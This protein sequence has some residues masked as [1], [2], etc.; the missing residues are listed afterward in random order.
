[1]TGPATI[2]I[3]QIRGSSA[4]IYDEYI[5]TSK[6]STKHRLRS[7]MKQA[8]REQYSGRMTAGTRKRLAR[9]VTLMAQACKARWITNEVTG[10]LQYHKLSF[11]TLTVSSPENLSAQDGYNLLLADFL[12][13][14]RRVKGVNTY[15]WKAE[16]QKRG[17]L[18]Y[19]ITTPSWIHYREIRDKWNELQ[20]NAGLLKDYAAQY[21]HTDPNSTDVHETRHVKDIA[22]YL[23]KELAKSMQNEQATRGKIWDCS[24]NLA[25]VAYFSVPLT[26]HHERRMDELRKSGECKMVTGERWTIIDFNDTGPPE[27]LEDPERHAMDKYLDEII[28]GKQ[29]QLELEFT[30]VPAVAA[31]PVPEW[32]PITIQTLF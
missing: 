27:L 5:F 7:R 9:A 24:D 8:R 11:I 13:W 28:N 31:Y 32:K 4:L 30:D 2:P 26:R 17:Q 14:M 6:Y 15:L 16:L 22:R 3:L 12:Q 25:G 23:V 29:S 19:H 18:H 10:Q 20:L 1:M 21:G